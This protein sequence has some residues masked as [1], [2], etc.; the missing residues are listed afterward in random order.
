MKLS[1]IMD[2]YNNP[3]A[4]TE[5]QVLKLVAGLVERGWEVR[6]AVFRGTKYTRN[7]EFPVAIEEL[8][9]GSLSN[10]G[11]WV[12][13][14]SYGRHLKKNG[15]DLVHVF[16]NDASVLCPPAMSLAGLKTV[17]SRR[18]MGFWYNKKYLQAL[19]LTKRFVA[20]VVCNSQAV[21]NITA[22]SEGIPA[23]KI[24]VIYNGYPAT[25][26]QKNGPN[27]EYKKSD[28]V[29]IG[30]VANLRPIKRIEDLIKAVAK[31][32]KAG[33]RS[34]L[35][36]VGG[37][38]PTHYVQL[39]D[40]LGIRD[41]THFLGSQAEPEKFIKD[42]DVA[43]LCSETEG[44]SNAIIEYI[45]CGKPV[46]CTRTGGNPEIVQHGE[47]GY[48]VDVGDVSALAEMLKKLIEN[49]ELRE[50]MGRRGAVDVAE[51]YNLNTMLDQHISLYKTLRP[52]APQ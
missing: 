23:R 6:F 49:P 14:Y 45:R 34:S 16:F 22:S 1:I 24:K 40:E 30:V 46:V 47:N 31:L 52:G 5:S 44:F 10:P 38:D 4:G 48:L 9:I 51:R 19:R 25:K 12:K 21:A 37:G 15:F 7:G 27:A 17:I 43:V 3:Y 36:I 28:P 26:I 11:S 2:Q 8:D 42:F 32:R 29:V 41:C 39:A 13:T 33:L 35:N 18:D 20:A 50:R